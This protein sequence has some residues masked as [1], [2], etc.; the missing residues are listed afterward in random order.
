MQQHIQ[1]LTD[2]EVAKILAIS[3]S[4]LWDKVSKEPDFPKPFKLSPRQTRWKLSDVGVYIDS[5]AGIAPVH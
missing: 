5:K 4:G 1:L 2:K 3:T